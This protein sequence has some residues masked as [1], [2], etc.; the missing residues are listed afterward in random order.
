[1]NLLKQFSGRQKGETTETTT[2]IRIVVFETTTETT[3]ST[4][5]TTPT[6]FAEE[7]TSPDPDTTHTN[8]LITERTEE[9]VTSNP[10]ITKLL[11][12]TTTLTTTVTVAGNTLTEAGLL[13]LGILGV[14]MLIGALVLIP[15]VAYLPA[16]APVYGVPAYG[17]PVHGDPTYG[18]SAAVPAP[19]PTTGTYEAPITN[20]GYQ[21][22]NQRG[23]Q[24]PGFT[25]MNHALQVQPNLPSV[26]TQLISQ[27]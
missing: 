22:P 21:T 19:H 12:E 20:H 27:I 11:L 18:D 25:Q 4:I 17:A 1:L 23:T 10:S 3:T 6:R 14:M 16:M 13:G 15:V 5:T 24:F 7:V 2:I 9:T 8:T 26:S